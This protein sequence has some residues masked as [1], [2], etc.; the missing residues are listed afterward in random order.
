MPTVSPYDKTTSRPVAEGLHPAGEYCNPR[1]PTLHQCR[2]QTTE[3]L[4]GGATGTLTHPELL[5][6]GRT[7]ADGR[8]RAVGR[9]TSLKPD[10]ARQVAQHLI[11]VGP[12]RPWTGVRFSAA[13]GSRDTLDPILVEPDRVAEISAETAIDRGA[14]RH[15]LRFVRIRAE[16]HPMQVP[17]FRELDEPGPRDDPHRWWDEADREAHLRPR[18]T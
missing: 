4:I 9:T 16:L 10:A 13:W 11:P 7:D 6:L 18:A 12:G 15:P 3:A 14:W 1:I 17:K 2:R 5:L 8:L